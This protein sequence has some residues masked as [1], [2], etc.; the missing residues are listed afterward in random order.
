[1]PTTGNQPHLKCPKCGGTDVTPTVRSWAYCETCRHGSTWDDF[2]ACRCWG[3]DCPALLAPPFPGASPSH[4]ATPGRSATGPIRTDLIMQIVIAPHAP[5]ARAAHGGYSAFPV[6]M[7]PLLVMR[8][9]VIREYA[10]ARKHIEVWDETAKQVHEAI[11]AVCFAQVGRRRKYRRIASR[12]VLAAIVAYEEAYALSSLPY[13]AVGRYSPEPGTEYPFAVSDV[14]RA[15]VRLLGDDWHAESTPWGVGA[16]LQVGDERGGYAVGVDSDGDLY[17]D[18]ERGAV[19]TVLSGLCAADGLD[20]I[21]ARVAE[22][23]RDFR[24][25]D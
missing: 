22:T 21:A 5:E 9:T 3:Y 23:V 25:D 14:G 8:L 10:A 19:R 2:K 7:A 17:V 24:K 15:A 1:M 16:V 11:A 20:E 12:V 4:P 18:A 13:D 6:R